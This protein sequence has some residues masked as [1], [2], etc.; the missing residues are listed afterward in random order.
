VAVRGDLGVLALSVKR[1]PQHVASGW[2]VG[3]LVIHGWE[4]VKPPRRGICLGHDVTLRPSLND[5]RLLTRASVTLDTW[6]D[7]VLLRAL[8]TEL[9]DRPPAC[10]DVVAILSA[11][12]DRVAINSGVEQKPLE[13]G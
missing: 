9:P 3:I 12:P 2:A 13:A 4:D 11:R 10:S 7:L 5:A 6:E 8:V 1:E